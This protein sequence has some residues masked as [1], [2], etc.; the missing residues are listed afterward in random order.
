LHLLAGV[1]AADLG[2]D[3]GG[4]PGAL[5]RQG[6]TALR[7]EATALGVVVATTSAVHV[8]L[9][10]CR[11]HRRGP[12]SWPP[13]AGGRRAGQPVA[14]RSPWGHGG[15]L[16]MEPAGWPKGQPDVQVEGRLPPAG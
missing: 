6:R 2:D 5:L 10:R 11:G 7:A 4:L 9:L 16:V 1:L 12:G 14:G 3:A 8:C 15:P 13:A